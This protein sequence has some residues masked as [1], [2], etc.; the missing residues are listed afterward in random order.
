MPYYAQVGLDLVQQALVAVVVFAAGVLWLRTGNRALFR[1]AN[2]HAVT[3]VV[4]A[5][6]HTDTGTYRRSSTG[7]GQVRAL[8][9]LG[10]RFNFAYGKSLL[11]QVFPSDAELHERIER[12]LIVLGG[13]KTNRVAAEIVDETR[14][15]APTFPLEPVPESAVTWEGA[16]YESNGDGTHLKRDHGYVVRVQNPFAPTG[17]R[18]TALLLGGASTSG[19]HAAARIFT[20]DRWFRRSGDY[21]ALVECHV[22]DG[23]PTKIRVLKRAVRQ[24][25][26]TWETQ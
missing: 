25:D 21:A 1:F 12:R 26:G 17:T 6:A 20:I 18:A 2:P 22:R 5:S 23:F 19:G 16:R 9:V 11:D 7:I 3:V 4:S 8:A 10:P 13:P 14:D 24:K 15:E